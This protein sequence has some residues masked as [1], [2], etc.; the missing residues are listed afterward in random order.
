MTTTT[1]ATMKDASAARTPVTAE[2]MKFV[3]R[4]GSITFIVSARCAGMDTITDKLVRMAERE[5]RE[6]A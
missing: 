4:I 6:S 1:N 5:V 3:E 2:P